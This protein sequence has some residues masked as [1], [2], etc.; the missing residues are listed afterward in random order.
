MQFTQGRERVKIR[1]SNQ[2]QRVNHGSAL[3]L[4]DTLHGIAHFNPVKGILRIKLKPYESTF[5]GSKQLC[6]I[7]SAYFEPIIQ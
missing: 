6:I 7:D 4:H 2:P 3:D 1:N 5:L